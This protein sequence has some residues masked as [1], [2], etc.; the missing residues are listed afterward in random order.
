M[1]KERLNVAGKGDKI[2]PFDREK[3]ATNYDRIFGKCPDHPA[4]KAKRKP[5]VDCI[6]CRRLWREAQVK[7]TQ[8]GN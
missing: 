7:E 4:Y 1:Y 3:Y 8:H 2:R 6:V 5:T